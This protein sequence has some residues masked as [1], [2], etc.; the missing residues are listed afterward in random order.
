M[1]YKTKKITKKKKKPFTTAKD[2]K[3]TFKRL[4]FIILIDIV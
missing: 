2:I 4:I 1:K 3:I